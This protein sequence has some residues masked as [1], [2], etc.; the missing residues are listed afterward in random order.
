M[1]RFRKET[2]APEET[3]AVREKS[4]N[5]WFRNHWCALSLCIIVIV[6]FALRTVF[7]YGISADGG[8]ALS[9]GSSAQYH[10]HVIESILNGS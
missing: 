5:G 2:T 4:G 1:S 6:A 8:F 7:A 10:L 3:G 9:G